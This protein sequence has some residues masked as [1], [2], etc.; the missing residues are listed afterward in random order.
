MKIT[1]EIKTGM[2]VVAAILATALFYVKTT[3][4]N[5]APYK[6]KAYFSY[7][8]GVKEDSIV[9]L[10]GIEVGRVTAIRFQYDPETRVECELTLSKKAKLHTDS[11]AFIS[12][13]GMIGDAFIGF[14]PGSADKPVVK[15][16][17]TV[18]SED[19]I[20]MRLFWKKADAIAS[21]LDK[22]LLEIKDLAANVNGVVKDNRP[23]IDSIV[24]NVEQMSLNFKDFS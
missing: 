9:K 3:D 10:S 12:T 4:F 20:Q 21:N 22:T 16:G 7:A 18:T 6:V 14:T 17:D 19:P 5:A 13:S 11:I 15:N 1:N 24:M 23:R 2:I 8:D